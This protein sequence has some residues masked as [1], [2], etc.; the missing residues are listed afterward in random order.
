[1]TP[2]HPHTRNSLVQRVQRLTLPARRSGIALL[3]CLLGGPALAGTDPI[4]ATGLAASSAQARLSSWNNLLEHG[5]TLDEE[6]KLTAVNQ[7]IN[8]SVSY[9][10]DQ[11]AWGTEEYW[12]TPSETLST[13]QGDCE[14][15]AIAKYFSLVK[16]GIPAERLRLTYV[17]ARDS[18]HMV[19]AYY[20]N[21]QD[22]PLILD[23]LIGAILP[24][25]ERK[26]LLPVYAFNAEGIYLAKAPGKKITHSPKL[27]SRWDELTARIHSAENPQPVL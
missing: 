3:L 12:A 9:V 2:A 13:G 18:A 5:S 25:A 24:A 10:S 4:G 11:Q 16:M 7:L 20:K 19:L 17:K 14:D 23:N 22:Q 8:G 6:G 27:L 15:F 26:D 1:M 21:P